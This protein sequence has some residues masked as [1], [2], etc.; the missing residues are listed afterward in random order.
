M[1]LIYFNFNFITFLPKLL[2][3]LIYIARG[4]RH[5]LPTFPSGLFRLARAIC[6]CLTVV[7][8]PTGW[9]DQ[10]EPSYPDNVTPGRKTDLQ[11]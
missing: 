7:L 5:P 2:P 8:L 1:G 10:A 9:D 4:A 3:C 6:F 11:Q